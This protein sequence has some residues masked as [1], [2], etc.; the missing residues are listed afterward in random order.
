MPAAA[1]ALSQAGWGQSGARVHSGEPLQLAGEPQC[2]VGL[3]VALGKAAPSGL[4]IPHTGNRQ[5]PS[6]SPRGLWG[7]G[8]TP[9]LMGPDSLTTPGL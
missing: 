8:Q 7:K 1:Q 3:R 2:L 4:F 9:L 5:C 6:S